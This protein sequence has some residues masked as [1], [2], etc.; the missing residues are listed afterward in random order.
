MQQRGVGDHTIHI[1][2]HGI[3]AELRR[4]GTIAH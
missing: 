4:V 3:E 2:D 1:E